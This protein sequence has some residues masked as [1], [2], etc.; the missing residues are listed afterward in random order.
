MSSAFMGDLEA[1]VKLFVE[2][3]QDHPE[4][5]NAL[6]QKHE[7]D[8]VRQE[9]RPLVFEEVRLQVDEEMRVLLQNLKVGL[10][11]LAGWL[12]TAQ[13]AL[14]GVAGGLQDAGSPALCKASGGETSAWSSTAAVAGSSV[15]LCS[16]MLGYAGCAVMCCAMLCCNVLCCAVPSLLCHNVQCAALHYV[17]MLSA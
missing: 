9:L 1:A 2:K 16:A 10:H 11:R 8:L 5:A 6:A 13:V 12:C 15:L 3:W 4:G 17:V 7:P 14:P